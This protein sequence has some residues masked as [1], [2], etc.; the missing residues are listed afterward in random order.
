MSDGYPSMMALLGLLALAG[1]QNWDKI[2]EMLGGAGQAAPAHPGSG[3]A[4]GNSGG[5]I[6]GLLDGLLGNRRSEAP[7]GFLNSGLG[8]MLQRFQQAGH[9]AAAQSWVNQGPNQEIAPQHLEQAIG[10]DV[11]AT[12]T[13]RTGLSREELLSR[14]SRELPQAVD[15]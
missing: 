7:G 1:Y 3:A 9:G 14:L 15:R 2:A 6:G 10:P 5:G 12:L 8:E 4:P 13:Q 11:P